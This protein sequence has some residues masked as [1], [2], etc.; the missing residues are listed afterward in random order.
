MLACSPNPF[1]SSS[2]HARAKDAGV[3]LG[4]TLAALAFYPKVSSLRPQ[5][6]NP[7]LLIHFCALFAPRVTL[8]R[9]LEGMGARG[10]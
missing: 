7:P 9:L 4:L 10:L 5:F 8:V 1:S 2:S 3:E 6:H